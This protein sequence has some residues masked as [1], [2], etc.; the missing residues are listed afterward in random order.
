M[1]RTALGLSLF[2]FAGCATGYKASYVTGAVTK[3]FSTESYG[4]YSEQFNKKIDDCCAGD[5]CNP[6]S[7][8]VITK[9]E[10][11]QCMG[12]AYEQESHGKIELAI[13]VYHE[14]AKAHSAA[15]QI[16]D[17]SDEERKAATN[18]LVDSA[19]NLLELLPDGNKLVSKLKKLTGR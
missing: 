5:S 18:A 2:L 4:I 15:M 8:D 9:T 10:L 14:A 6:E 7:P 19:I 16:V 1:R 3:Q 12:P 11:D 17:G 13:K